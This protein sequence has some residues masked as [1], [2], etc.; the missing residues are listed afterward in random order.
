MR[1][2]LHLISLLLCTSQ[3][4]ADDT[5]PTETSALITK[6]HAT[7]C[8]SLN[9]DM[10]LASQQMLSTEHKKAELKSKINYLEEQVR[11]RRILIEDLDQRNYQDNNDNY[12]QLVNQYESLVDERKQTILDYNEQHQL[13]VSQHDSVI[14]LEQRFSSQCLQQ[15]SISEELH[16]EVCQHEDIRWCNSF[17]F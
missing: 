3:V 6:E 4:F 8:I 11:Q 15:V 5:T 13:H 17:Q 14:R 7:L 10:S 16:H 2:I 12:N 1:R 9:K